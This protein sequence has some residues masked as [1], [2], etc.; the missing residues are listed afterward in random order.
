MHHQVAAFADEQFSRQSDLVS[1]NQ[2]SLRSEMLT[3]AE[4][5]P[6]AGGTSVRRQHQTDIR[7]MQTEAE[8]AARQLQTLRKM[9]VLHYLEALA[10]GD[11]HDADVFRL[12]ALWFGT[13]AGDGTAEP[14]HAAEITA[15]VAQQSPGIESRKFL[16]LIYQLLARFARTPRRHSSVNQIPRLT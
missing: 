12:I 1:S 6:A 3:E 2:W 15:L 11:G 4:A 5:A 14:E 13:D 9:A 16:P 8:N 10:A 7:R